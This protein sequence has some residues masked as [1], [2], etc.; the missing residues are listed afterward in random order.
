MTP[1]VAVDLFR[2][3][4][5]MTAMIVGVLVVPS[6]LVGLVVAMFQAAT[7]INEQTLSFLPR[8]LVMLLTLIWA[9]PWLVRE[10]MEYTQN[11]VQNIPLLIG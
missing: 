11:L 2:E 9:G 5:W 7:Q 10:L 3:G 1:E 4:L 8:L 6:L